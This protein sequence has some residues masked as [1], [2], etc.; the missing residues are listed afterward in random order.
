[1]NRIYALLPSVIIL[2]CIAGGTFVYIRLAL[3]HFGNNL[4]SVEWLK[5]NQW[6]TTLF[7]A[8]PI[9]YLQ[10]PALEELIFRGPLV[11]AFSELS[12]SAWY[13]ILLSAG[14]FASTHWFGDKIGMPEILSEQGDPDHTDDVEQEVKRLTQKNGRLVKKQKLVNVILAFPAGLVFGYFGIKYQSLWLSFGIHAT[15][16]I[17]MPNLLPLLVLL[18]MLVIRSLV[19]IWDSIWDRVFRQ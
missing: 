16:N 12:R 4:R 3:R 17:V 13:W 8:I 7:V 11:L 15:W 9:V 2:A 5:K 10:A 1:M 18:G 14:L 19:S 6:K